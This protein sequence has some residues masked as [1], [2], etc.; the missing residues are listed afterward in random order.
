MSK[1]KELVKNTFIISIGKVSTQLISFLLLPLYTSNISTTD[2]G[3][4][5]FV[6][7]VASF[8]VP[9]LTLLLE[10]SMF[11]F[12]IDSK[13]T[14]ETEIIISHTFII[15]GINTVIIS[16]VYWLVMNVINYH[17]AF[18]IWIYCVASVFIALS[19]ALARGVGDI[20]TYSLSNFVASITTIGFNLLFILVFHMGFQ[21]LILS[22]VIANVSSSLLV[23]FKINAFKY[24][25]F[26]EIKIEL[27]KNMLRYSIPLVPNTISWSVINVSDRLIIM[28]KLGASV[29][30]LY[31]VA[32]KFPNLINTFYG[33]FVIA[34][35]E[36]SAKM[37][38]DNDFSEMKKI[39]KVITQMLFCVT[40]LLISGIRFIYPI[41][42]NSLYWDGICVVPI[43]AI[44]VF[45]SSLSGYIGGVFT[46]YKKTKLLGITSFVSAT[47]NLIVD[48]F[49]IKWIGIY[50]AA[51]STLVASI[52]LYFYRA[53]IVRNYIRFLNMSDLFYL[54]VFII[55]LIIF[56]IDNQYLSIIA[57]LSC[58]GFSIFLN[59][60]LI[61]QLQT[62]MF[63]KKK[64]T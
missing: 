7:S 42:I 50:A 49:L 47:I 61:L 17:L 43:L 22:A 4:F 28:D 14:E 56:Y 1:S 63:I 6:I 20:F 30:G 51:I 16:I 23:F 40:I 64:K 62:K 3:N 15:S 26:K 25:K 31:S 38:R 24:F 10:E 35:K 29:N 37:V 58:I 45:Y 11:R 9:F 8:A 41:F 59:K 33:F 2:Y 19:N 52:Y 13:N 48:L 5:D 34:W 12:L 21:S 60:N 36:T 39:T 53:I 46:A 54:F 44:S 55:L 32:Y 57:F 18:S 27:V